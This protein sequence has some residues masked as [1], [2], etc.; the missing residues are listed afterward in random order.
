M[1]RIFTP[2]LRLAFILFCFVVSR[3]FLILF[4]VGTEYCHSNSICARIKTYSLGE[5]L[6]NL[7]RKFASTSQSGMRFLISLWLFVLFSLMC[8]CCCVQNI[9]TA[10]QA[11][12][13]YQ[14]LKRDYK[15][16]LE[17]HIQNYSAI[18]GGG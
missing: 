3:I 13:F 10:L 1:E 12:K 18:L 16:Y 2:K 5:F 7:W 9:V 6:G 4:F 17:E 15:D 14:L 8:L 11:G